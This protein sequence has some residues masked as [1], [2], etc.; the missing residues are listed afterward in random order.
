M[1]TSQAPN[2]D[3]SVSEHIDGMEVAAMVSSGRDDDSRSNNSS[4]AVEIF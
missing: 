2:T 1:E 3:A 4:D